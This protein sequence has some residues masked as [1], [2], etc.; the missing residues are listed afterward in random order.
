MKVKKVRQLEHMNRPPRRTEYQKKHPDSPGLWWFAGL[1]RWLAPQG[2]IGDDLINIKIA[3]PRPFQII[4]KGDK[5]IASDPETGEAYHDVEWKGWWVRQGE[6][7]NAG[8][9]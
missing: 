8:L 5:L 9:I 1:C 3:L 7:G 2:V 6:L 4:K